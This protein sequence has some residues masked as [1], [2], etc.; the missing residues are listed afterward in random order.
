M[1]EAVSMLVALAVGIVA[2]LPVGLIF[3]RRA[4]RNLRRENEDLTRQLK[5]ALYSLGA[6][7]QTTPA[8]A[9]ADTASAVMARA[10]ETQDARG[11]VDRRE[12]VAHFVERGDEAHAIEAAIS[13]MCSAG[14]AREDGQWLQLT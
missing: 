5:V 7:G 14:A 4:T 11:R 2:G 6:R 1:E 10:L 12:L 9:P 8:P 3:E 13:S